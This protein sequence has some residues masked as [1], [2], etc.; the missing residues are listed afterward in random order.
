MAGLRSAARSGETLLPTGKNL[1]NLSPI[2]RD[3]TGQRAVVPAWWG[4]LVD[5]APAK[6]ALINTR[7]ERLWDSKRGLPA[8]AMVPATAWYEMKKPK[9]TWHQFAALPGQLFAMAAV[10][11]PGRTA[12]APNTPP[13]PS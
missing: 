12:D 3:D 5:G 8:R 13:T 4:Y 9:R 6:F 7:A 11:R 2:I 10:T 1:R